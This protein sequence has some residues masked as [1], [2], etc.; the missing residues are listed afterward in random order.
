M[1][2][3]LVCE[4]GGFS[5]SCYEKEGVDGGVGKDLKAGWISK[6]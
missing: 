1:S 4:A 2:E 5:V 3:L 6:M